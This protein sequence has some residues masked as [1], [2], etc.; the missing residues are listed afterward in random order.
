MVHADAL[1]IYNF[2]ITIC[3]LWV[4]FGKLKKYDDKLENYN[5]KTKELRNAT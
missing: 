3:N 4:I 1:H 2:I 5:F